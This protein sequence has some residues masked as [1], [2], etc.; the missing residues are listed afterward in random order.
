M[1]KTRGGGLMCY[2]ISTSVVPK[3]AAFFDPQTNTISY[4]VRDPDSS[5]CA[6]IDSVLDIDYAAGRISHKS[7]DAIIDYIR[8]NQLRVE[9]LIETHAHADH[10]SAAPYIQQ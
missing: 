1:P 5:S 10:L 4:V 8:L 9:W 6:V 7:A 2:Q 3:V